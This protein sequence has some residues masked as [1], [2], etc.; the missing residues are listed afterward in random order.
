MEQIKKAIEAFVQAGDNRDI[1]V[2]ENILHSDFQN[3]QDGFFDEKGIFVFSKSDYIELIRT[4]KFGGSPRSIT[5]HSIEQTG[6]IATVQV[7]LE[8]PYLIFQSLIV[9]VQDHGDWKII[10][11]LPTIEVK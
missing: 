3:I 10:N 11:N 9:C 5:Y 1:A 4:K 8:S 7:K 2:L 6:N